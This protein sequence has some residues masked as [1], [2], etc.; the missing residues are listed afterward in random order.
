VYRPPNAENDFWINLQESLDLAREFDIKNVIIIGDLNADPHTPSGTHLKDFADT[1]NLV[2]HISEPMRIT[3]NSA[4]I[5]DQ[6]LT[7]IPDYVKK[8]RVEP[9]VST[10]DHCTIGFNL[11]FKAQKR[12]AFKRFMWN[13]KAENFTLFHE[14]LHTID[15]GACL[16]INSIDLACEKFTSVFMK[17]AKETIPNKVVTVRPDDKPWFTNHLRR[18]LYAK[19]KSH[20]TAKLHDTHTQWA[21]YREKRNKYCQEI[22]RCKNEYETQKYESLATNNKVNTKKWWHILKGVLGQT[23]DSVI[24][25]L[26]VNRDIIVNDK[27]KAAAFNDYFATASNL[28][29]S[30]HTLPEMD[31]DVAVNLNVLDSILITETDVYDQLSALDVTKAYG[32]DGVPP[33]LLKEA[34]GSIS[35]PLAALFN[36]SLEQCKFPNMWKRANVLPIFKKGDKGELGNYR[37]VSLLSTCSKVFERIMFKYIYNHFRDNFLISIWQS[38]FLPSL[39]TVMQL[40]EMYHAFCQ[41]VSDGKEIR[42]VFLDI[43]KAFDRV[44]HKGLIWKLHKIG[45]RGRLLLWIENYLKERY[46][47]VIINGQ[48]SDWT[49]IIAGVP[50]GS[51]LGPLLFLVFIN[52]ITSVINHCKIRLFADDTCLFITVDDREVAADLINKDLQNIQEWADKWLVTFSPPKTEALII[53]NKSN[54]DRHPKLELN[55]ETITEV[56]HHKHLGIILSHNLRWNAHIDQLVNKG[57]KLNNMMKAFKFKLDRR[58]LEIIYMSFIRPTLE[59]ADVL[60]TGTYDSDLCKLDMLQ[61]EAMRI[62][63]GATARSNIRLLYDD[64]GWPSLSFRRQIHCLCLMY[65]IVNGNAPEYLKDLIPARDLPGGRQNLRSCTNEEIKI[66][67]A[68]TESFNRSFLPFTLRLWNDLD[69]ETR[70]I[71]TLDSFKQALKE[72]KDRMLSIL[73]YGKRPSI[74]HA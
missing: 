58:S 18:L 37:P 35:K 17:A 16:S 22:E 71:L 46:Q 28:D 7:N 24:P 4:S 53:S 23:H 30:K 19:N 27:R 29:D 51:V 40:T 61:V 62:V 50:Q 59:Y 38:G 65:K 43:S 2:L 56:K 33:L 66:P 36:K 55:G 57:T 6:I 34:K 47:R 69:L 15:W 9:P 74:Q 39:S 67:F 64:L 1:N 5:L 20:K 14:A 44:W 73:Y 12:F 72:P 48:Y 3:E 63:T 32:P 10:N 68:R 31:I 60:F 25:P 52:D 45:I 54:L 41:A 13:F 26:N 11:S 42:V 70:Q 21:A 8:V 49:K